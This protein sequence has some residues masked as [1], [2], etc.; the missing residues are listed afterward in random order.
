ME[1]ANI[2]TSG[3][4][5]TDERLDFTNPKLFYYSVLSGLYSYSCERPSCL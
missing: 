5:Q 1:D 3:S 2:F 4:F